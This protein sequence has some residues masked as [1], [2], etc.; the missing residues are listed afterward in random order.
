MIER[1]SSPILSD[2]A[3]QLSVYFMI[4]PAEDGVRWTWKEENVIDYHET[5]KR[6]RVD[7]LKLLIGLK[8][9]W[10]SR[11]LIDFVRKWNP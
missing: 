9:V 5:Q 6:T 7:G 2:L 10:E 8:L 4:D 3:A 11:R 1:N